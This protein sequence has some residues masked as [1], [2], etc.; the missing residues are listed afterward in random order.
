MSIVDKGVAEIVL[1]PVRF[2][3]IQCLQES[4]EPLYI[5]QIAERVDESSR[6]VSHHLDVLED[7][8]LVTS[9]FKITKS[10]HNKPAAARFF[11]VTP[12]LTAVLEEITSAVSMK[13]S[14]EKSDLT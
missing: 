2:R 6:L 5:E 7:L 10:Q 3:I 8:G 11:S 12:R 14:K 1:Q 9:E 4:E 13:P